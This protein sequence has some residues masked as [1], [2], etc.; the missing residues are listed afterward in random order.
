MNDIKFNKPNKMYLLPNLVT[1]ANLFCGFYSILQT[2]QANFINAAYFILL[3]IIFDLLDGRVARMTNTFSKFGKEYDSLCDS[4]SFGLAP[5]I[6]IYQWSLFHLDFMGLIACFLYICC[7]TLR[8]ARFNLSDETKSKSF[9]QG[10]PIP[11]A[12]GLIAS[13][14][15]V[16]ESY[17]SI[18][19]LYWGM[20]IMDWGS[21][22][23]TLILSFLMVSN[24]DYNSFKEVN[25]KEKVYWKFLFLSLIF[26]SLMIYKFKITIF[27][28]FLL[29]V[30]MGIFINLLKK[31]RIFTKQ[32]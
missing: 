25:L 31:I 14:I 26:L 23:M 2:I 17:T 15:L 16:F 32:I 19:N 12:A 21:L 18:V 11:I 24:F 1:T 3:A 30:L 29:Y 27:I 4:I 5:S 9:F 8:L 20:I 13:S 22:I 28:L 10:L 6:L 7:G